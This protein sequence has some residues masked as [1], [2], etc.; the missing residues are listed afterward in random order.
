MMPQNLNALFPMLSAQPGSGPLPAGRSDGLGSDKGAPGS[1]AEILASF[2]NLAGSDAQAGLES[3]AESMTLDGP[4]E[5]NAE[6]Q[7]LLAS[8]HELQAL[9][10]QT[11][12]EE[13]AESLTE[14]LVAQFNAL[15]A[16]LESPRPTQPDPDAVSG[17]I[18]ALEQDAWST[19]YS[20]PP[21]EVL[22]SR[23]EIDQSL[24]SSAFWPD[25]GEMILLLQGIN[26]WGEDL[27]PEQIQ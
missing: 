2:E 20:K 5:R 1:W 12:S 11:D 8:L 21:E 10:V 16:L 19:S 15:F 18:T 23:P 22:K 6:L 4:G 14:N 9:A 27:Q 24:Y 17:I 13:D 25:S 3:L 7:A 26:P